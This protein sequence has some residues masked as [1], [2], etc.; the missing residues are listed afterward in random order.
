VE[1]TDKDQYGPFLSVFLVEH[2]VCCQRD[3]EKM[4]GGR[5]EDR[6]RDLRVANGA[7]FGSFLAR[8]PPTFAFLVGRS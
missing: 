3:S 7:G 5:R 4:T 2:R 8:M 1:S 6:T